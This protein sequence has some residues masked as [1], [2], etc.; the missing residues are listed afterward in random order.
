MSPKVYDPQSGSSPQYG[1]VQSGSSPQYS[2]GPSPLS[3]QDQ[4]NYLYELK[5][6]VLSSL[7]LVK[8]MLGRIVISLIHKLTDRPTDAKTGS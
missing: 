7:F 8:L 1:A 2:L 4:V 5:G 6:R 3:A